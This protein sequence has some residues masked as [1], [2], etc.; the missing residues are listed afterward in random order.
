MFV[1]MGPD[2]TEAEILGVKADPRGGP[3]A[4]RARGYGRVVIAVVGDVGPGRGR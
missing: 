2:A 3:H 4:L 1:V